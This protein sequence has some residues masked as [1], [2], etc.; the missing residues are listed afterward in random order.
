MC[1][2]CSTAWRWESSSHP[3]R[4]LERS[5][6]RFARYVDECNIARRLTCSL[7]FLCD[8]VCG[9]EKAGAA[10]L[11]R[12]AAPT[13]TGIQV[14]N[15]ILQGANPNVLEPDKWQIVTFQNTKI[16]EVPAPGHDSKLPR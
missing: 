11:L 2:E 7:R 14:R 15:A 12:E 9:V 13:G 4:E 16:S 8:P 3:D 10:A 1:R 6:H 5:G